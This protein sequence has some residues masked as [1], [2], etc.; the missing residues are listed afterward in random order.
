MPYSTIVQL[1]YFDGDNDLD[2]P[3]ILLSGGDNSSKLE[4]MTVQGDLRTLPKYCF[5]KDEF[6]SLYSRYLP[7]D[8]LS[9][10]QKNEFAR[11]EG[12]HFR[13]SF[14]I[15][16]FL[17]NMNSYPAFHC[18]NLVFYN[19][20]AEG[21]L[22]VLISKGR[23]QN[24]YEP[25]E[26]ETINAQGQIETIAFDVP[27]A[28]H[29]L[30]SF[31][32]YRE[33]SNSFVNQG[34][35]FS[36]I[37]EKAK[38][39]KQLNGDK[40]SS[41]TVDEDAAKA[42]HSDLKIKVA[43]SG[44]QV[45]AFFKKSGTM[46]LI[47]LDDEKEQLVQQ[48]GLFYLYSEE[49]ELFPV[50]FNRPL[51]ES[52]FLFTLSE[53]Q[54]FPEALRKLLEKSAWLIKDV[55]QYNREIRDFDA[56]EFRQNIASSKILSEKKTNGMIQSPVSSRILNPPETT[57]K[58][59]HD[60]TENNLSV[61]ERWTVASIVTFLRQKGFEVLNNRAS[62]GG[63][64]VLH[65]DDDFSEMTHFLDVQQI[66]CRYYPTGRHKMPGQPQ[67]EIDPRKRLPLN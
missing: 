29:E 67:Y 37:L 38:S 17:L 63:I 1:L 58:A 5:I 49:R 25:G 14:K 8:S 2:E 46:C 21:S 26:F 66:E 40:S 57:T 48:A 51:V 4:V 15:E 50:R 10:R 9:L 22:L 18:E 31:V 12:G 13:G 33:V 34:R 11:L 44:T 7:I 3:Y 39:S 19:S 24:I 47:F 60:T 6:G 27:P 52:K 43:R 59:I 20:K 45:F 23:C 16:K 64:W 53:N 54:I 55:V 42:N 41:N 36:D 62:N 32:N 30:T 35:F 56:S 65:N 28:I 61:P